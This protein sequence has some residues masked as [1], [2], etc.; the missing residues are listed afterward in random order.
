VQHWEEK[1]IHVAVLLSR[2]KTRV[3]TRQALQKPVPT[4]RAAVDIKVEKGRSG[5]GRLGR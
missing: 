4:R 2:R 1:A 5:Y 3:T